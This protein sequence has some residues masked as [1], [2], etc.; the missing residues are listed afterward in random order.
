PT[1]NLPPALCAAATPGP[2]GFTS[3]ASALFTL[4]A[5]GSFTVRA[6]G[7][8]A[9]AIT[10]SGPLPDGVTFSADPDGTATLSGTPVQG[11]VFPLTMTASDGASSATQ[12]FTLQVGT[13]PAISSPSTASFSTGV[14]GS[15]QVVATGSPTPSISLVNG[16]LPAGLALSSTGKLVGTPAATSSGTYP[17]TVQASDGIAPPASQ[18]VTV[19]VDG[20]PTLT[21]GATAGFAVGAHASFA[22]TTRA[23]PA[24]TV[25]ESGALVPGLSFT[26]TG[27]GDAVI[28]GTPLSAADFS[29]T[30]RATNAYGSTV[31]TLVIEIGARAQAPAFTSPASDQFVVAVWRT[32][33]FTTTGQPAPTFSIASGSLPTELT[34][35][36]LVTE[37]TLSPTGLLSGWPGWSS[38]GVYRFVVEA[39]NGVGAPAFQDFTLTVAEGGEVGISGG[40]GVS[41][42]LGPIP[43]LSE[44]TAQAVLG[45]PFDLAVQGSGLPTPR[46]TTTGTLPPGTTF[47]DN[48]NG[49]ATVAGTPTSGG[50]FYFYVGASNVVGGGAILVALSVAPAVAPSFASASTLVMPPASPG[51]YPCVTV[52]ASGFPAPDLTTL[53]ALPPAWFALTSDDGYLLVCNTGAPGSARQTVLATSSAG[54][55]TQTLTVD[56][57]TASP[58][59]FSGPTSAVFT[60]GVYHAVYLGTTEDCGYG[61]PYPET[62]PQGITLSSNGLLSGVVSAGWGGSFALAIACKSYAPKYSAGETFTLTVPGTGRQPALPAPPSETPPPEVPPPA[63]NGTFTITPTL[64]PLGQAGSAYAATL[65]ATAVLV[66]E[67]VGTL[68]WYVIGRLPP[69]LKIERTVGVIQGKLR[70]GDG[71]VYTFTVQVRGKSKIISNRPPVTVTGEAT[72]T[73]SVVPSARSAGAVPVG[74][75]SARPR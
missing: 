61:P 21:S 23:A 31:Q 35:S 19:V 65:H 45:Q 62:L 5:P 56:P 12:T 2:V 13:A 28:A 14:A 27:G 40:S 69:G 74:T 51:S 26:A 59:P 41:S 24:A 11:G 22:I 8:P 32:F 16:T 67:E 10:E 36:G 60:A 72:I 71:G 3:V 58:P 68:K 48:G 46:F 34:T 37:L 47:T 39:D 53:G 73:L 4:G 50:T 7:S 38:A 15:F 54:Q 70:S 20:P 17:I 43:G 55:A 1:A 57:G 75:P 42:A 63:P 49:T 18:A 64:L 44:S 30:I 25:T 29:V 66:A 9:P 33:Q 52:T 6:S